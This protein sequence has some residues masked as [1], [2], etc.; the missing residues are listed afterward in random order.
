[1][2]LP[3]TD[4]PDQSLCNDQNSDAVFFQDDDEVLAFIN[5]TT[6]GV[7]FISVFVQN[8]GAKIYK[9]LFWL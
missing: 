9:A 3:T 8:F 2:T 1:M 6:K 5:L 4:Y 7:N